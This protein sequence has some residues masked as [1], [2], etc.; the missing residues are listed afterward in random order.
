MTEQED[1]VVGNEHVVEDDH[2]VHLFVAG[3]EGLVEEVSGLIVRHAR[4][5]AQARCVVRDG[6]GIRIGSVGGVAA[7]NR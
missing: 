2:T 4:D 1:A 5:V 6:E 3:R 7:Q